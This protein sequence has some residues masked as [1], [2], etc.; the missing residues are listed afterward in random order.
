M[1]LAL[2][3]LLFATLP[4]K[5]A[6]NPLA[7]PLMEPATAPLSEPARDEHAFGHL[8]DFYVRKVGLFDGARANGWPVNSLYARQALTAHDLPWS[9]WL[10]VDRLLRDW[11]EAAQPAAK[12]IDNGRVRYV[13]PLHRND[14]WIRGQ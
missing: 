2:A 11:R 4:L 3:L 7:L 6:E 5:A 14:W 1:R 12:V 8:L 13:D 10:V 9:V